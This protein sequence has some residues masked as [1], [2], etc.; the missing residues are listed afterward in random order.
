MNEFPEFMRRPDNEISARSQSPGIRG[1]VFDGSDG[2]QMAIWQCMTE[3]TS[4]E[5]SH[6]Y[7]EYMVVVQGR[8]TLMTGDGEVELTPGN[9]YH[10]PS[11]LSHSGR[12]VA[13]TRT[14]HAFGGRRATRASED[15][16]TKTMYGQPNQAS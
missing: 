5:H 14:I 1:Y 9:E 13:G 12:W 3:G 16:M 2:S 15:A 6:T 10:I 11:D 7:D 4:Q 8:Y